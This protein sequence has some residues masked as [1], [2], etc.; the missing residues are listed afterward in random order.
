MGNTILPSNSVFDLVDEKARDGTLDINI[1]YTHM[2]ST[3]DAMQNCNNMFL[4]LNILNFVCIFGKWFVYIYWILGY[5][6]YVSL[7]ETFTSLSM[8]NVSDL[9]TKINDFGK[10][11]YWPIPAGLFIGMMIV[12]LACFYPLVHYSAIGVAYEPR[13]SAEMAAYNGFYWAWILIG[14]LEPGLYVLDLFL[15][16]GWKGFGSGSASTWFIL[17]S[18][19]LYVISMVFMFSTRAGLND[20][21]F[22]V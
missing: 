21:Y 3:E 4:V 11:F 14:W 1:D 17:G 2:N 8:D 18:S 20:F 15:G 16:A 19:A 7:I 5:E 10:N 13:V 6:E 22:K 12:G 9:A